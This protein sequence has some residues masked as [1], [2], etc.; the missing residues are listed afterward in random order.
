MT[1]VPT[2]KCST[3]ERNA[4]RSFTDFGGVTGWR[5]S[6]LAARR[7]PVEREPVDR[8]VDGSGERPSNSADAAGSTSALVPRPRREPAS[9]APGGGNFGTGIGP[10][11]EIAGGISDDAAVRP[12]PRPADLPGAL[13][14]IFCSFTDRRLIGP[15]TGTRLTKTQPTWGTGLPPIKR[16]SSKSHAYSP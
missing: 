1:A 3:N 9:V 15:L 12:R 4:S 7:W 13:S 6:L 11:A 5:G 8:P 14:T 16:P 10:S 2:G